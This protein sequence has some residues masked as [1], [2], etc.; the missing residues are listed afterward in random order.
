MAGLI[1]STELSSAET[2]RSATIRVSA[3]VVPRFGVSAAT[4]AET[5]T[6]ELPPGT[7]LGISQRH[8]ELLLWPGNRGEVEIQFT[9][10]SGQITQRRQVIGEPSA[11]GASE[12]ILLSRH[13]DGVDVVT[14]IPISQ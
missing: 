5:L 4:V 8:R 12:A 7:K 11:S 3:E 13:A 9:H 1:I 2:S 10:E 14:V 6:G